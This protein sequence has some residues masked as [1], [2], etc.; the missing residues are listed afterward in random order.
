MTEE[1]SE[2]NYRST[3]PGPLGIVDTWISRA[4]SAIL[5][6]GVILMALNTVAN[7]V[8]RF[9]L[10]ESLHFSEE[11]NRILIVM[12]TFAGLGYAARHGR[13]IRMSAIYDA[14]PTGGRRALMVVICLF[15]SLVMFVLCYFSIGYIETLY[16][17]GRVLPSL[18]IPV[19][20]IYLWV[21]V[22]F[23]ITGIQYLLTA[24]K[25]LTS[26]DVYLSTHVVDGYKD[27]E[28]EV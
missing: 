25:N 9:A 19:W 18:S 11:I 16:G 4:E 10:G 2:K 26:R 28:T 17:R 14:L 15:T 5:A 24:I 13:H 22:G 23:T 21:P 3:L 7:V 8:S 27:T 1:D 12:I 6:L 20:I